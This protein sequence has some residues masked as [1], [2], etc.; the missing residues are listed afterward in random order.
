M[1]A[2]N[3]TISQSASISP[4]P[5]V[6]RR[7]TAQ[8]S[9]ESNWWSECYMMVLYFVPCFCCEYIYHQVK[10]HFDGMGKTWLILEHTGTHHR[11]S[12]G[13]RLPHGAVTRRRQLSYSHTWLVYWFFIRSHNNSMVLDPTIDCVSLET[14]RSPLSFRPPYGVIVGAIS[15]DFYF[16]HITFFNP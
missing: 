13:T 7:G 11:L 14:I 16:C 12:L 10:P 5:I 3:Q 9:L 15:C 8:P 6:G 1:I 4:H 2:R